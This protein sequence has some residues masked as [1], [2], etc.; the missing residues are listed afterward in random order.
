MTS[1]HQR[2]L[3]LLAPCRPL[4]EMQLRH[5]QWRALEAAQHV[6]RQHEALAYERARVRAVS[7]QL[8]STVTS[9]AFGAS[10]FMSLCAAHAALDTRVKAATETLDAAQREVDVRRAAFATADAALAVLDRD[11]AVA[12]RGRLR[13][14]DELAL[15][16]A[17][18]ASNA[19]RRKT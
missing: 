15:L 14:L 6:E 18:D 1:R 17:E 13:E 12:K 9:R 5:A 2:R 10:E 8:E 19:W 7:E 16:Q 3:D 11:L 4:R